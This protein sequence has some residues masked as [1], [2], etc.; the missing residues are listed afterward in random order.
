MTTA[1]KSITRATLINAA[2]KG[3]LFVECSFH[4]VDGCESD[5]AGQGWK[6]VYLDESKFESEAT[7]IERQREFSEF[8][9]NIRRIAG[10]RIIM[11]PWDFR[12]K[13]G[14]VHGSK[15][16]GNFSVHSNLSYRYEIR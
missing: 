12:T 10:D 14:H 6:Q 4:Y 11:K 5:R 13:S 15:T 7:G 1:T 8:N 3:K 9:A 2:R 16:G